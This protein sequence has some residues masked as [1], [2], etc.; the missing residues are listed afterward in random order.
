MSICKNI[1]RKERWGG[2]EGSVEENL[3]ISV[4]FDT[5]RRWSAIGGRRDRRARTQRAEQKKSRMNL[6]P[7][8]NEM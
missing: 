7:M 4:L 1:K 2:G 8:M 6:I 5:S 3:K